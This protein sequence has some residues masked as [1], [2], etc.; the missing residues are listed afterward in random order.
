LDNTIGRPSRRRLYPARR[1]HFGDSIR[2]GHDTGETIVTLDI[3]NRRWFSGVQFSVLVGV[4]EDRPAGQGRFLGITDSVPIKIQPL[5][6]LNRAQRL[7]AAE[8]HA[9]VIG[10]LSQIDRVRACL[11]DIA[12]TGDED[13]HQTVRITGHQI[14]RRRSEGDPTAV[15]TDR[16]PARPSVAGTTVGSGAEEANL[17]RLAIEQERILLRVHIAWD[18]V[19]RNGSVGHEAA[20]S[21]D[22]GK[23]TGS[24][25]FR[26]VSAHTD[27]LDLAGVPVVD[28]DIILPIAVP[29]HEVPSKGEKGH[30]SPVA[31]EGRIPTAA[32]SLNASRRDAHSL[33][34][35]R[36]PVPDEHVGLKIA[37]A[38]NQVRCGRI[39]GDVA[40]IGAQ[41][42][43]LAVVITEVA[44]R[45][46]ADEFERIGL[47]IVDKDVL[48]VVRV[49]GDKVRRGRHERHE[50]AIG[51]DCRRHHAVGV[52][53]IARGGN[54]D[55][56]NGGRLSI[57]HENVGPI[58][59]IAGNQIR[60]AGN[61]RDEAT[62][63]ADRRRGTGL[64]GLLSQA[65]HAHSFDRARLPVVHEDVLHAGVARHQVRGR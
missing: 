31:A 10:S 47:P 8:V 50:A 17:A 13:V 11:V 5:D 12:S 6:A 27:S 59:R 44:A 39:E 38:S 9:R 7:L 14:R 48:L 3:G 52:G 55:P 29:G 43:I 37:V 21:A 32:V 54:A 40:A 18:K 65:A 20:V 41:R 64:V 63:G 1:K 23:P 16:R 15:A 53:L 30:V 33:G 62:V 25:R 24:V 34:C 22:G 51:A 42:W 19:G 56:L 61:E 4:Q 2:S 60:R 49:P 35:P 58:I 36:L 45:R 57:V 46:T 28:K 26:C